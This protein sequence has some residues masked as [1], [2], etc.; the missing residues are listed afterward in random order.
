M[1]AKLDPCL[2]LHAVTF[3]EPAPRLLHEERFV[4]EMLAHKLLQP[5]DEECRLNLLAIHGALPP[6]RDRHVVRIDDLMTKRVPFANQWTNNGH[7]SLL[8]IGRAETFPELARERAF[9]DRDSR[10]LILQ[11]SIIE[12]TEP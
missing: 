8:V 9:I 5:G 1:V 11:F 6:L 10:I 12:L 7:A 4:V 3:A 2:M